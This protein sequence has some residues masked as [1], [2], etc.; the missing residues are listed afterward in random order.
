MLPQRAVGNSLAGSDLRR[1]ALFTEREADRYAMHSRHLNEQMVR[2]LRTIGYDVNFCRG[3]GP[4]LYDRQ[5]ANG[6]HTIKILPSLTSSESDRDRIIEAFDAIIAASH[7][8]PGPV[9]T[10][11][12]TLIS[13]VWRPST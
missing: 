13:H 7:R 10:L 8:A 2:V 3:Q 1:T 5:G 9:W 11:G 12:K 6:S 4:Y